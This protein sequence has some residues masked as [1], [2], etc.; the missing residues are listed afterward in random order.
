[1]SKLD[2]RVMRLEH[3]LAADGDSGPSLVLLTALGRDDD[4]I[5]SIQ[6]SAGCELHR[7]ATEAATDFRQR[8]LAWAAAAGPAK[9]KLATVRYRDEQLAEAHA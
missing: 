1:M 5:R 4:D 9:V 2:D 3:A 7:L 6:L 8:A